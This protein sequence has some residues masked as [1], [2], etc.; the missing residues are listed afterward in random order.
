MDRTRIVVGLDG[1]P[2]ARAA[3]GEAARRDAVV[4]AI[5][6]FETPVDWPAVHGLHDPDWPTVDQARDHRPGITSV[7]LTEA[8]AIAAGQSCGCRLL[9]L[10]H[11]PRASV[12]WDTRGLAKMAADART[13]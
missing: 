12:D 9:P 5:T 1:S 3:L 8:Q 10:A 7:G 11:V 2:G 6:A 4:E 13:G